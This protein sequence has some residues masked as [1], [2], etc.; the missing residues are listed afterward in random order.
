MKTAKFLCPCLLILVVSCGRSLDDMD[1][2]YADRKE[3]E[4][5]GAFTRG[6]IPEFIP[7]SS[8]SIH[9]MH[10]LDTN[11]GGFS[12]EFGR[13]DDGT[14]LAQLSPI[15]INEVKFLPM[16]ATKQRSW[17]PGTLTQHAPNL[18]KQFLF[19]SHKDVR[20]IS[21]FWAVDNRKQNVWCWHLS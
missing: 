17:W 4:E 3:A 15:K 21:W 13:G 18:D 2:A 16:P 6:W 20:G 12:F 19:Y 10:N 7:N 9:E 14:M 11:A 5:D 1:V 8:K